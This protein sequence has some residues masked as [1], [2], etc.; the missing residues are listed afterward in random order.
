MKRFFWKLSFAIRLHA[1]TDI[2]FPICWSIAES[3]AEQGIETP[4]S[5]AVA[6]E[7]ASWIGY[8]D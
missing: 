1:I 3:N 2:K 6:H 4:P 5:E 8:G 7:M